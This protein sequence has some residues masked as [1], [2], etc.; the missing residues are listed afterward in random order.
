VIHILINLQVR[1]K[2][3]AL[4]AESQCEEWEVRPLHNRHVFLVLLTLVVVK[5]GNGDEG[6]SEV[7]LSQELL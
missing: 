2:L 6:V 5:G 1:V 7:T 4:D 3:D